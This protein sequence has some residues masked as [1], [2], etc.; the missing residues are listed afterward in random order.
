MAGLIGRNR[1]SRSD[2]IC[3]RR[4]FRARKRQRVWRVSDDKYQEVDMGARDYV[5][6]R[7]D[8]VNQGKADILTAIEGVHAV[9]REVLELRQTAQVERLREPDASLVNAMD[10]NLSTLTGLERAFD[11]VVNSIESLPASFL[12]VDAAEARLEAALPSTEPPSS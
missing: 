12:A 11:S 9:Q 3:Q 5:T 4:T 7:G 2:A 6:K 10:E 1:V 8:K